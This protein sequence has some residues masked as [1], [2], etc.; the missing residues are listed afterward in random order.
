MF[1]MVGR[2]YVQEEGAINEKYCGN[3]DVAVALIPSNPAR[4]PVRPG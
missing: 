1:L 4:V 2:F 3:Y